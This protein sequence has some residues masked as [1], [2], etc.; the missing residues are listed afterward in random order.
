MPA[1]YRNHT[2]RANSWCEAIAPD[3]ETIV[4]IKDSILTTIDPSEHNRKQPALYRACLL[5][6]EAYL[7]DALVSPE[8]RVKPTSKVK[9]KENI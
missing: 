3:R 8:Q 1:L 7:Q 5:W 4:K 6:I 2:A 9:E